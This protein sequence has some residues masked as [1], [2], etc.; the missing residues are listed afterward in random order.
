MNRDHE[1]YR[2]RVQDIRAEARSLIGRLRTERLAKSR[3]APK[4]DV[5]VALPSPSKAEIDAW[6]GGAPV[7]V[8]AKPDVAPAPRVFAPPVPVPSPSIPAPKAQVAAAELPEIIAR[9]K[10]AEADKPA[11]KATAPKAAAPKTATPKT[12][13]LKLLATSMPVEKKAV[14]KAAARKGAVPAAPAPVIE[15]LPETVQETSQVAAPETAKVVMPAK[16]DAGRPEKGRIAAW[17]KTVKPAK[18]ASIAI[19]PSPEPATASAPE[20]AASVAQATVKTPEAVAKTQ[21]KT[22]QKSLQETLASAP[23]K[24]DIPKPVKAH[25]RATTPSVALLPGI[26]P[27]LV[28]R[29]EQS[30]YKTLEDVANAGTEELAAKLGAVGKLVKIDRWIDFAKQAIAA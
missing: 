17:A 23:A 18:V 22:L 14:Q 26:G 12:A 19:P 27:G 21:P 5:S 7:I 9:A 20:P 8:P 3:F 25:A 28:W 15:I 30:G 10:A 16:P 11:R 1:S 4:A 2:S 24:R 29:L 13:S 6:T